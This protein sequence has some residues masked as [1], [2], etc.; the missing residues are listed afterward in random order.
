[1]GGGIDSVGPRNIGLRLAS[2]KARNSLLTLVRC[3][4]ARTA[5]LHAAIL[6]PL[7]ALARPGADQLALELRQAT[8]NRQHQPAMS[9]RGVRPCVLERLEAGATIGDR[10]DDVERLRGLTHRN[11]R[12]AHTCV[13]P[14]VPGVV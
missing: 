14:F 2:G 3:H 9:R 10:R 12:P 1:N 8:E 4:L 5:E 13:P 11:P 7:A 6:R